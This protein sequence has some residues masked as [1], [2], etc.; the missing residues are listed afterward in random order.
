VLTGPIKAGEEALAKR[1]RAVLESWRVVDFTAEI[2][3]SAARLRAMYGLNLPDAI[4]LASAVAINA[5][6]LI[7]HDRD[8]ARV[9]GFKVLT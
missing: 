2:A 9:R 5:E 1:Y 3:E 4:Q 8:F 7:T 6:A